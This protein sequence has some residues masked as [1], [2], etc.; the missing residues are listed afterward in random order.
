LGELQKINI[1]NRDVLAPLLQNSKLKIFMKVVLFRSIRTRILTATTVL[2]VAIVGAVVWSWAHNESEVYY[3]QKW[4]EAQIL[5]VALSNA[6]TNELVDQNWGQIRL[7]INLLLRR[8]PEFV[9]IFVSDA[10]L[11]NQIVA[12]LP[13]DFQEQYIPDVVPANI[14][15]AALQVYANTQI[16]KTVVLRDV[17]FPKGQQR[18]LRGESILEVASDMRNAS[19]EKIGTLRIGMSLRQVKHAV[20][21]AINNALL[22]GAIGLTFG[23]IGAYILAWQLSYPVLRLQ[24][25]ATK[26][27]AGDL[28]HRADIKRVD[29][30]GAL[31]KAFNEMATAL[32]ESFNR[33]QRTLESFERFVPGKFLAVIASDGIEN[34]QVGVASARLITILFA[35]IRGYTSMSEQLTPLETF[36]LLND[37]LACMGQVINDAGGFIDKY[38]GDAIMALFEDETTGCALHAALAMQQT[39]KTFNEERLRKEQPTIKIGI[40]IHRGEVVMG[41]IGFTSRIESTVIG[42]TVN[43]AARVEGLTRKYDCPILVTESVVAAIR[44]PRAFNL[45]LVDDSVKVKGKSEPVAIYELIV[46]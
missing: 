3:Q 11:S 30:L 26:I 36:A 17:E 4:Q 6:W 16:V 18:A 13:N 1:T 2:I 5:S 44:Y 24:V 46:G 45:R 22:V 35:D 37:Y 15:D 8:N 20:R 19:G 41:T 29:E 42:D 28:D 14:T 12:A 9:Y 25:S 40:G 39:L 43:V 10:R 23:L 7:G 32:Q 38:I 31:S 34:I 21:K 33:L 27:A